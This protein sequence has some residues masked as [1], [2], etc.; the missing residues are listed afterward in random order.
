LKNFMSPI[1]DESAPLETR[2]T[3]MTT[4]T[5]PGA[6]G[7]L[8]SPESNER[9]PKRVVAHGKIMEHAKKRFQNGVRGCEN[10]WTVV[11]SR[12]I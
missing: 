12:S 5:T 10:T 11:G 8:Q 3:I 1:K 9:G 7:T 6:Q 4:T 2:T